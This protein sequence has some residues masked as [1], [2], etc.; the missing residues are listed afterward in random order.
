[1]FKLLATLSLIVGFTSAASAQTTY[2]CTLNAKGQRGW[3]PPDMFVQTGVA[4]GKVIV[5]S[6]LNKFNGDKPIP[7]KIV[8]S[9]GNNVK[10]S[11]VVTMPASSGAKLRVRYTGQLNQSNG[12]FSYEAKML[13]TH[14]RQYSRGTCS[15][16]KK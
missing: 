16:Y 15:V 7:A 8:S 4:Q 14:Q 5:S 1:M 6:G 10:F 13:T 9:T 11:H 3:M 12:Q 2:K